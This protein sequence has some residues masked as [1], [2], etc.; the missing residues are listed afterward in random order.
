[1]ALLDTLVPLGTGG[2]DVVDAWAL[3]P[4]LTLQYHFMP[5]S[6]IW[7]YVDV[8]LNYTIFYSKDVKG[9]LAVDG[10]VVN[11]RPSLCWAAQVGADFDFVMAA[12]LQMLTLHY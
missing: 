10:A 6:N 3:P 8:G 1:M 7:L 4:T 2:N 11:M 5:D 9:S 12:G